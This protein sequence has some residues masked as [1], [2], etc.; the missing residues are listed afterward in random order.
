MSEAL[1]KIGGEDE[2]GICDDAI[3][4]LRG[5]IGTQWLVE[6]SVDFDGVE[7]FGKVGSFV[8]IFRAAGWIEVAS[9]IG[10]GPAGGTDAD[11]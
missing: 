11:G 1:P 10:I 5:V 8:E 4:P 7:E 3:E 2:A 6:G 9:P